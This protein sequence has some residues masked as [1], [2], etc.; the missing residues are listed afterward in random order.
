M[1]YARYFFWSDWGSAAAI[2]RS[3]LDGSNRVVLVTNN[4][5]WPGG[6]TLDTSQ[7]LVYWTDGYHNEVSSVD[8]DGN[9]R[10]LILEYSSLPSDYGQ[11]LSFD[12]DIS[13][14]YLYFS[15]W[16]T[17][18]IYEVKI[19]SG[20]LVRN[21]SVPTI[22]SIKGVMGLRVIHSAKQQAG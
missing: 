20:T 2:E 18:A 3:C 16:L 17:N 15:E 1:F 14:D 11:V 19:S 4:I 12:L 21:I 5:R 13:G 9:N 22:R 6:V 8:Y 7:R 10:R